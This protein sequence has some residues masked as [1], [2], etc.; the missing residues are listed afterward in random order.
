MGVLVSYIRLAVSCSFGFRSSGGW[1]MTVG[2][3]H[4]VRIPHATHAVL[5]RSISFKF[6]SLDLEEC[7]TASKNPPFGRHG[8][9][10]SPFAWTPEEC[11]LQYLIAM[12]ATDKNAGGTS[13][14]LR[15]RHAL[16]SGNVGDVQYKSSPRDEIMRCCFACC[17]CPAAPAPMSSSSRVTRDLKPAQARPGRHGRASLLCSIDHP[18]TPA[19]QPGSQGARRTMRSLSARSHQGHGTYACRLQGSNSGRRRVCGSL[20]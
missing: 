17:P 3:V 16:A 9:Y 18:F 1:P 19:R 7:W 11:W 5:R 6:Q 20:W 10:A 2:P 14:T 4:D 15:A 13:S 8:T 12:P